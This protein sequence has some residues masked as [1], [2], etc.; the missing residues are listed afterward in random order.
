MTNF[1]P[2]YIKDDTRMWVV[3]N[4]VGENFDLID[5]MK[6]NEDGSYPIFFSVGGI[7]LD[8]DNVVKNIEQSFDLAVQKKAQEL[9]DKKYD[10]LIGELYDIQERIEKQKERFKYDWED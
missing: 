5:K 3:C 2:T 4:A 6:K 7:E 10:D 1:V 9:L 8:F